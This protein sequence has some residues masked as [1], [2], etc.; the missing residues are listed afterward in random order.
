MNI[1][2][3]LTCF[4]SNTYSQLFTNVSQQAGV[5]VYDASHI[6]VGDINNDGYQDIYVAEDFF[7][8]SWVIDYLFLN[9]GDGTFREV[10]LESGLRRHRFHVHHVGFGDFD[11]D[12][13]QDLFIGNDTMYINSG[14]GLFTPKKIIEGLNFP[15][16]I[17]RGNFPID[18]NNDGLLDIVSCFTRPNGGDSVFILINQGDNTFTRIN[19]QNFNVPADGRIA[20]ADLNSDTKLDLVLWQYDS[21]L[22]KYFLE[23]YIQTAPMTFIPLT[24]AGRFP[25]GS[26]VFGDIDND[27]DLDFAITKPYSLTVPSDSG[28]MK[29]YKNNGDGTFSDISF[30]SGFYQRK[31]IDFGGPIMGDF[32]HDGYLDIYVAQNTM[33]DYL[34]INNQNGTFT[35]VLS[36][37]SNM[38]YGGYVV[39]LD[40]DRDLDLDLYVSNEMGSPFSSGE[41]FLYRNDLSDNYNGTNN[42]IIL[43]FVGNKSNR[44]AIGARV[45]C[46]SLSGSKCLTQTRYVGLQITAGQSMLPVHFG[47]G[48]SNIIDSLVIYWPSGIKQ[49][50]YNLPVNQYITITEDTTLTNVEDKT[51]DKT[52]TYFLSQNYPNPF[53]PTARIKYSIKE[54]GLVTLKIFD[55]LGREI[56]TLVNEPKQP[57]E[58]EIEFDASK[59]G[60]SSGVY[61]YQLTS[62]AFS[63]TKKFVFMK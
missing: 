48:S 32:N 19:I 25:K 6:A 34:F 1:L 29:L 49:I 18:I 60:L 50:V 38:A 10:Y 3:I 42:S 27:G 8:A 37:S 30:S 4:T 58:Y 43:E 26:I 28:L 33:N 2:I 17:L 21:I 51:I 54:A 56:T 55:L 14:N 9:N 16:D 22:E 62:G 13:D 5:N 53:N 15:Y 45:E 20:W 61:I 7:L 52:Y 35:N 11:N 12:G 57:G 46:Y 31:K 59:Y 24:S 41:N 40:Y 63:S 39:I 47:L 36:D 44:N 23:F